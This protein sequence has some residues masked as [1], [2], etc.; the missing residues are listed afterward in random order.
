MTTPAPACP[1]RV[2]ILP[3]P[4]VTVAV[5]VSLVLALVRAETPDARA[6]HMVSLARLAKAVRQ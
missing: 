3:P 5:P 1:P 4:A 6:M 2:T